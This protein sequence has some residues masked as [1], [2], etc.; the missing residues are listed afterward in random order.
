MT[1]M[2]ILLIV[3]AVLIPIVALIMI[4]PKIKKKEKSAKQEKP[5]EEPAKQ[6]QQEEKKPD[7]IKEVKA[8]AKPQLF[9]QN[10]SY[11][12][13]DFKGYL[14]EKNKKINKPVRKEL[15]NDYKDLTKGYEEY[16]RQ[17]T[18]PE[19]SMADDICCLSPELQAMVLTGILNRKF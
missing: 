5:K 13:D 19:K 15:S 17:S 9:D 2:E 4:L 8:E 14:K 11:S 3:C 16:M 12:A 7:S 10:S 1:K 18:K 6:I